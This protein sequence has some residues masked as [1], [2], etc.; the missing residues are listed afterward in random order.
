MT[1]PTPGL[2]AVT[3]PPTGGAHA[4]P[5]AA[6]ATAAAAPPVPAGTGS[7]LALLRDRRA[8]TL[9]KL[10]TDVRV[11]RWGDSDGGPR[12]FVRYAPAA[13]SEFQD[14][15]DKAAKAQKKAPDW[16]VRENSQILVSSCVGVFAVE[17]DAPYD[18]EDDTI[19]RLSLRDGDP[20]GAWTKF[21]PDLA[22]SLGLP[23]NAGAI[24][25]VRALYFT[26]PD[27]SS[28]VNQLLTW[29]GVQMPSSNTDFFGS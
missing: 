25:V 28:T 1:D 22:Y 17:G 7:A 9:Q 3:T 23:E 20:H 10:Y 14:R 11:P 26:E 16:V 19:V 5:D 6:A 2:V 8:A 27:I 29:S 21:D 24:A 18:Q 4:A 13:P 15:L 12:I